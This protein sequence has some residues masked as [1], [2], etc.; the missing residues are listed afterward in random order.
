MNAGLTSVELSILWL[1]TGV[2]EEDLSVHHY[3]R[4]ETPGDASQQVVQFD[5]SLPL[6]PLSYDGQI[7]KVCWV[8]RL[9]GFFPKG[10][11]RVVEAPFWLTTETLGALSR[12]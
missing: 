2:G 12:E 5:S 4:H 8:V 10:R 3:Q 6:S 11:Q 9:R 7:V 1:T